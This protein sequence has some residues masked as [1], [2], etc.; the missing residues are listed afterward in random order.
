MVL[1]I[2]A[3]VVFGI[4]S[5]FSARY[6]PVAKEGFRCAFR[7]ITFRKCDVHLEERIRARITSHLMTRSERVAAAVYH[8]FKIFSWVFTIIFFASM[9]YT[10]YSVYNLVVNG[11]CD[12]TGGSCIFVA[13]ETPVGTNVSTIQPTCVQ[14]DT[15][16][17]TVS[18]FDNNAKVMFFY[19]DGCPWCEKEKPVLDLLAKDGYKVKPMHLDVHPEYI[20]QYGIKGTPTFIGP[21]GKKV[22]GYQEYAPLRAFLDSYK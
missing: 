10:G 17:S 5:I 14:A 22:I 13:P 16:A 12:P 6:R 21:D 1:C 15:P 2:V 3:A 9:I 8:H 11:T 20:G 4:M 19:R 18:Y 7:M